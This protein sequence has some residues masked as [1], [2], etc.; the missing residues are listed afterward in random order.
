MTCSLKSIISLA[1][2]LA[3][4]FAGSVS[5]AVAQT[6]P[7]KSW[8]EVKCERYGKAWTEAL[9]RRGRKG[10]SPEFVERHEAFL[11]SGCTTKAD[12]CPRSEEELSMANIMV[13][14]AMNAGT[15]STFPPFACRK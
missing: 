14:A 4:I 12:V 15:A 11:A 3:A 2:L 8:P 13:V 9:T 6:T 5:H 7:P 10:L 1:A